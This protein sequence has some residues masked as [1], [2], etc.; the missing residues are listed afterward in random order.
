MVRADLHHLSR[1]R[2]REARTLLQGGFAA[3]AYYLAGYAVECAVKACIARRTVRFEFAN[4][5]RVNASYTHDLRKLVQVAGLQAD[6]DAWIQA[7][8]TFGD[9]WGLVKDWT[10]QSRYHHSTT[11][12][13]A[14]DLYRAIAGQPDGV[15]RWL[16]LH[17]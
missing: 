14:R 10:E 8:E 12:A 2:L 7:N 15:M 17:W 5:D 16:R 4:R 3:G 11:L 9:N 6:L 13:R 1:L